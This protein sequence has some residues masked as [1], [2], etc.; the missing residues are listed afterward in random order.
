[1]ANSEPAP[2]AQT[3]PLPLMA[4]IEDLKS[5]CEFFQNSDGVPML[6]IREDNFQKEWQVDDPRVRDFLINSYFAL[7]SEANK[8]LQCVL[9]PGEIEFL[10]VLIREE[11]RSS[12]VRYSS[13]QDSKADSDPIVQGC[14][15]IMNEIDGYDNKSSVLAASI[16]SLQQ[17]RLIDKSPLPVLTNLFTR[18]LNRLVPTLRAIGLEVAIRHDEDGS[19]THIKRL[20]HFSL[21]ANQERIKKNPDGT[22]TITPIES[23]DVNASQN[24]TSVL[25]D[26]ADD[27]RRKDQPGAKADLVASTDKRRTTSEKG[28]DQ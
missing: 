21:E 20:E 4:V 22:L 13:A 8:E 7:N 5:K 10:Q 28:V 2:K 3:V 9:K 6:R 12:G 24:E 17:S 18:R 14:V 16:R 1:M 27:V 15:F 19:Y 26:D 25:P 11:C 23:S